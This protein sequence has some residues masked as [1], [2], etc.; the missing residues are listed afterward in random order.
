MW[1]WIN[2]NPVV[3]FGAIFIGNNTGNGL[4]L[5]QLWF[6]PALLVAE[7]IFI[8]LYN[9]LNKIGAEV[10]VLAIIGCSLLGLLIGKIY[11]LPMGT[12]IA[13]VSQIFILVGVLIRKYDF[14]EKINLK[15]S[16]VMILIVILTFQFNS[17]VNM[18]FRRYGENFLF[19]SGGIAGT[20]LVMKLS[21]LMTGGKIFL[22]ISDCGRQ[23]MMILVMHSIIANIFY[24]I[25][26][27]N[28]N[29]S[30]EEFFTNPTIIFGATVLGVLIP[31][32]I[33]KKFGKLPV[34]KYFCA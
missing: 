12:D 9:Y 29:F 34:I 1:D 20:L 31:L 25:I 4:I 8:K 24:E 14:V 15:T 30:P 21:A 11:A 2:E 10:F 33:A 32:I 16:I 22:L 28:T 19:Y 13:L 17:L 5:G 23:S 6:L 18:T 3:S 26:A 7:I 27:R